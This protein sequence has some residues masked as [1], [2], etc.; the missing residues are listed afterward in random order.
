MKRS[1]DESAGYDLTVY[2]RHGSK[3]GVDDAQL[4]VAASPD[5]QPAVSVLK[6][7]QGFL[8]WFFGFIHRGF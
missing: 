3:P 7:R 8:W 5:A 6:E 4:A 2:S 1:D